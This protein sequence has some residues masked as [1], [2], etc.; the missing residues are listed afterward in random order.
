[1][2]VCVWRLRLRSLLTCHNAQAKLKM[3][4]QLTTTLTTFVVIWL[5]VSVVIAAVVF[6]IV[7]LAWKAAWALGNF[8]DVVYLV[9]SL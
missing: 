2:C 4:N 9:C 3:Y 8:W 5:L 6:G 7:P 1:M